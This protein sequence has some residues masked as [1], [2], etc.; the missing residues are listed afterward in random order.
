MSNPTNTCQETLPLVLTVAEL[1][2]VLQISS[3]AAYD[4]VRSGQIRVVRIG[5]HIRIPASALIEY[6]DTA[7]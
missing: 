5:K 3:N 7:D 2:E 1:S 4:L 6:L